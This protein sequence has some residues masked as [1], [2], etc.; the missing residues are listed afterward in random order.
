MQF[1]L[2]G[3]SVS[4]VLPEVTLVS[5]LALLTVCGA[6]A[7]ADVSSRRIPNGLP[8]AIAILAPAYWVGWFGLWGLPAICVH[9]GPLLLLALPLL[10][11]FGLK[12]IAGG[13]VKLMLAVAL[14][15][16]AQDFLAYAIAVVLTGGV[17]GGGT[18]AL[19]LIFWRIKSDSVPYGVAI[20]VGAIAVLEPTLRQGLSGVCM[21][22]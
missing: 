8:L 5:V 22:G 13:D 15:I 19:S 2:D 7:W 10:L 12:V 17:I 3:F 4:P 14:W 16:P 9:I 20:V 11:L 18:W 6:A 21:A 1:F